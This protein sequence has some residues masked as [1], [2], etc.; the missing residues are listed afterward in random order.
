MYPISVES[1]DLKLNMLYVYDSTSNT[2][3]KNTHVG[4]ITL[5][6]QWSSGM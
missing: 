3:H 2:D 1:F 4:I 5:H 6:T